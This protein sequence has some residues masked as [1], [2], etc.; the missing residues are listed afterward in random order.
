MIRLKQF[1]YTKE[2]LLFTKLI[3]DTP[4][5]VSK[6]ILDEI[7]QFE[8][9]LIISQKFT[10]I[11]FSKLQTMKFTSN[12]YFRLLTGIFTL[13]KCDPTNSFILQCINSSIQLILSIPET[14]SSDEE[15]E[16][17]L[18]L[19]NHLD[20]CIS[21][22]S[23]DFCTLNTHLTLEDLNDTLTCEECEQMLLK[24][25]LMFT[26]LTIIH[27]ECKEL[28]SNRLHKNILMILFRELMTI[29]YRICLYLFIYIQFALNDEK[30]N[31]QMTIKILKQFSESQATLHGILNEN[32]VK[33]QLTNI[34]NFDIEKTDDIQQL[35]MK[36]YKVFNLNNQSV[37][38]IQTTKLQTNSTS[39]SED[40]ISKECKNIVSELEKN[41][42]Y[43][44]NY[45]IS[46]MNIIH[47][48]TNISFDSS[49]VET[50]DRSNSITRFV[51]PDLHF[52]D[53][54]NER[55]KCYER[56]SSPMESQNGLTLHVTVKPNIKTR[57]L[58]VV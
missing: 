47:H 19:T 42:K 21:F 12:Q 7:K 17:L 1:F 10:E 52:I 40:E 41:I 50:T 53:E 15:K 14:Y 13:M 56:I 58:S 54:I 22:H 2:E 16:L 28:Y 35:F 11:I 20:F 44:M 27:W 37:T 33:Q 25:L 49:P 43:F 32:I 6:D 45:L 55:D 3:K 46:K 24:M 48:E 36:R 29:F 57:R 34:L 8:T 38:I 4:T 39:L 30:R 5:H 51:T 9:N 31:P 18:S 26:N 23:E